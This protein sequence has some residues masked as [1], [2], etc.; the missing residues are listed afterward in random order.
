MGTRETAANEMAALGLSADE[1][2]VYR[3]FLRHPDTPP[4]SVALLLRCEAPAARAAVERLRRIGLLR[5]GSRTGQLTPAD[6]ETAVARLTE[7]RLRA[8]Y[9]EIQRIT[10]SR[11]ILD[12]LRAEAGV[13]LPTPR[14]IE[15]LSE[16][17]EVRSRI[18]DLAFFAREEILSVEP[19]SD[20]PA[21]ECEHSRQLG[22]RALRRGVRVRCVV[23]RAALDSPQTV[24]VLGELIS[25]GARVRVAEHL[26]EHILVYDRHAA[27]IPV[28]PW[29][30]A[31][32]ALVAH[33]SGLVGNLVALFEKIWDE[34]ENISVLLQ[35]PEEPDE[36]V[37]PEALRRVLTVMCT[38]GKDETGAKT[39]GVSVRTYRRHIAEVMQ[40][41][42]AA[43]R[44][45]AA[46]LARERGWI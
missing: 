16:L 40:R 22:V 24:A 10:Q 7:L 37:L 17:T 19:R 14:G 25:H 34:A 11:H 35:K 12:T 43:T 38:A 42:N 26:A 23:V 13:K 15:Q 41:L 29:D 36:A 9:R 46:L 44:A 3:H 4:E 45:E 21:E 39:L 8:L 20:L 27:L 5:P 1:E 30:T 6:P 33:S 28:D 31:R 18:E 2:M 32:G